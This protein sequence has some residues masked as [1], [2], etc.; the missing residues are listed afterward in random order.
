MLDRRNHVLTIAPTV[1][2]VISSSRDKPILSHATSMVGGRLLQTSDFWL[3]LIESS[4]VGQ[5]SSK[6]SYDMTSP[7]SPSCCCPVA[8]GPELPKRHTTL[9]G[10]HLSNAEKCSRRPVLMRQRFLQLQ[11][12]RP[13]ILRILSSLRLQEDVTMRI[14]SARVASQSVS[15]PLMSMVNFDFLL[16]TC[17][18]IL[19]AD[20]R[21][22]IGKAL[23]SRASFLSVDIS[24]SSIANCDSSDATYTGD[25][26]MIVTAWSDVLCSALSK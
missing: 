23:L 13:V 9:S 20:F 12:R 4:V 5:V 15:H 3:L 14:S 8:D 17:M 10:H 18:P 19:F 1:Y 26:R 22:R 24:N 16:L 25:I 7:R 11:R 2:S 6:F 21:L